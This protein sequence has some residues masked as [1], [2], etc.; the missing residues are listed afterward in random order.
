MC[1]GNSDDDNEAEYVIIFRV[2]LL[3]GLEIDDRRGYEYWVVN[4]VVPTSCFLRVGICFINDGEV[5]YAHAP[6]GKEEAP[7]SSS[8]TLLLANRSDGGEDEEPPKI[9]IVTDKLLMLT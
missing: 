6:N 2:W 7:T 1:D 5:E 8:L 3:L 4:A 9:K